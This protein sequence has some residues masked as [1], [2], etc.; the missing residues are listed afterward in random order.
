MRDCEIEQSRFFVILRVVAIGE[1]QRPA[2]R[3]NPEQRR[4][5]SPFIATVRVSLLTIL[6]L[7]SQRTDSANTTQIQNEAYQSRNATGCS[8]VSQQ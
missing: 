6:K 2:N 5:S 1:R 4:Q 8:G 7:S 3:Q